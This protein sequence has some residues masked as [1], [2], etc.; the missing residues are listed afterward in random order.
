MTL[1]STIP[2]K[3]EPSCIDGRIESAK[4]VDKVFVI[5]SISL[6]R[7]LELVCL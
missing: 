4:F 3:N 5:D 1:R 6:V 2:M 7:N